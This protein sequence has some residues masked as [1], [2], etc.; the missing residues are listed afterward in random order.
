MKNE[1]CVLVTAAGAISSTS[2]I[3]CLKNN[4]DKRRVKVVCT[5]VYDQPIMHFK[6]DKFYQLPKGNSKNYVERLLKIC[7]KEKVDVILPCS[8]SEVLSISKKIDEIEFN[9][10]K[11]AVSPFK[12]VVKMR[13]KFQVYEM[14]K[15]S[16]IPIPKSFL[17]KNK[18]QFLYALKSLGFPKNPVCFKPSKSIS[19]GGARGFR[20]LS[21]ISIEKIIFDLKSGSKEIDFKTAINAIERKK[22]LNIITMEYLTGDHFTVHV[23]ANK[24]EMTHCIPLL[25]QRPELGYAHWGIIQDNKRIN[26]ICQKIVRM[27]N[28]DFIVNIQFRLSKGVPHVMEINP[29]IAGTIGL[30]MAGGINLPYLA[31]KK[32]LG[33]K[34]PKV[35]VTYG[36]KMIKHWE[37]F[38]ESK[39]RGF[40]F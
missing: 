36:V 38:Y 23:M 5:D 10:I 19:S 18:N 13:D 17:V 1:I 33:E 21:N 14:L 24:G 29:R 37:E 12:S 25:I 39:G 20:I 26:S 15:K 3:D 22:D 4:Y 27:M 2:K 7:K 32:A 16:N 11:C 34:L 31:V 9:G 40:E 28:F 8:L 35:K 30:A 6:A